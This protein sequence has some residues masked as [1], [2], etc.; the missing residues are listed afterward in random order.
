MGEKTLTQDFPNNDF[1]SLFMGKI[2][3]KNLSRFS[4]GLKCA[5]FAKSWPKI[6]KRQL[7]RKYKGGEINQLCR[8]SP[9]EIV[10]HFKH[11]KRTHHGRR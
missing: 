7:S 3:A 8:F 9:Q 2:L 4:D 1:I 6:S 11:N 5:L 10:K